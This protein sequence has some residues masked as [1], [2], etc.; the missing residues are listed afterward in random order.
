MKKSKNKAI[1]CPFM[2]GN[3]ITFPKQKCFLLAPVQE[4]N[5]C[6]SAVLKIDPLKKE[7][8]YTIQCPGD[9]IGVDGCYD[10]TYCIMQDVIIIKEGNFF[11]PVP[12]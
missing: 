5:K 2:A 11:G 1:Y 6:I 4:L 10:F 8:T 3:V 9:V 7:F 12:S